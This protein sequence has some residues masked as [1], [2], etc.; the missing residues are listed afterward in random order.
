MES[1]LFGELAIDVP[2]AAVNVPIS[3]KTGLH[4]RQHV[5]W[6]PKIYSY[7]V[8]IPCLLLPRGEP[9]GATADDEP[10]LF[11]P[12]DH[13]YTDTTGWV[14]EFHG[15]VYVITEWKS[16]LSSSSRF[17]SANLPPLIP[18]PP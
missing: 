7:A 6:H 4:V 11:G 2:I 18:P 13:L 5:L 14:A 12:S 10:Q 8:T 9:D 16:Q 1:Y 3:L 17:P 15:A